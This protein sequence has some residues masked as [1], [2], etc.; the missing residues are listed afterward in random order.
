MIPVRVFAT[1]K[2]LLAT[3][4]RFTIRASHPM[5]GQDCPVCEEP[6]LDRVLVLVLAG[7]APE[8]RKA[9]GVTTGAAVAVH[10]LCAGYAPEEPDARKAVTDA[11][12]PAPPPA[13]PVPP[14]E[15]A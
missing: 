2:P 4:R 6:L 14:D 5:A 11:R 8:D 10:A 13:A 15:A 12:T 3:G 7:I 9:D 1:A